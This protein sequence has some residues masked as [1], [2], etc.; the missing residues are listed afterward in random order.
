MNWVVNGEDYEGRIAVGDT[1]EC[2]GKVYAVLGINEDG[3]VVKE[4]VLNES[5][6]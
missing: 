5:S 6:P 1:L 3:V 2:N 4:L